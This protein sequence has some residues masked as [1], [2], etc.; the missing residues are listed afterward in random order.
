M[1]VYIGDHPPAPS[2]YEFECWLAE[3]HILNEKQAEKVVDFLRKK[4]HIDDILALIPKIF[5]RKI[6]VK[7]HPYD[8]WNAGN[9]LA[10]VILPVV[11]QLRETTHS[12]PGGDVTEEEWN[13]ILEKI[14]WSMTQI[15][16]EDWEDQ[17]TIV[18]PEIDWDNDEVNEDGL[19]PIKW[20]VRGEYDWDGMNKHQEKIQEGC[21]LLGKWFTHLWD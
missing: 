2:L 20:K 14:E 7:I 5:P 15:L 8:S 3:K 19:R 6:K 10:H 18:P 11:K 12:Y 13:D 4:L 9:T 17:Y 16:D 21:E 1:R